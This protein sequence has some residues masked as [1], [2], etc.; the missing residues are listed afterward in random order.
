M[1]DDGFWG[2]EG[3]DHFLMMGPSLGGGSGADMF[4]E[5]P[6]E[7]IFSF[8]EGVGVDKLEEGAEEVHILAIFLLGPVQTIEAL[9]LL[10][11]VF[12]PISAFPRFEEPR[13]DEAQSFTWVGP[14]KE[15]R[16]ER[17]GICLKMI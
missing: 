13:L 11:G 7:M 15:G 17:V 2:F 3:L 5:H 16:G 8:L 10:A 14:V 6:I 1:G 9:L 12:E 4:A